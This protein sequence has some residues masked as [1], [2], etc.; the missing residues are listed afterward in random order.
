MA[1]QVAAAEGLALDELTLPVAR[2]SDS[3]LG[4]E[5]LPPSS[6]QKSLRFAV[7]SPA[8][9]VTTRKRWLP[10]AALAAALFVGTVGSSYWLLGSRR[11][12]AA[13]VNSGSAPV[14]TGSAPVPVQP[15]DPVPSPVHIEPR[16]VSVQQAPQ[17][18]PVFG[19]HSETAP[20]ERAPIAT[21]ARPPGL[22]RSSGKSANSR[23]TTQ[24]ATASHARASDPPPSQRRLSTVE[25]ACATPY[26]IDR[27]GVK[28]FKPECF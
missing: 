3:D 20:I 27:Q 8:L 4:S 21:V 1:E 19:E 26:W 25:T 24:G 11:Q 17:V 5:E 28:R 7:S 16:E 2:G 23:V 15:S 14:N 6:S 22:P 9:S 12:A 13:L 10:R 18:I